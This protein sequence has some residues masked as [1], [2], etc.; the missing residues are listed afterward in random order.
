VAVDK[1]Q[2][3]E[4]VKIL[5]KKHVISLQ[6]VSCQVILQSSKAWFML[7]ITACARKHVLLLK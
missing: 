7:T 4:A 5:K 2:Q 6:V 1:N 3:C